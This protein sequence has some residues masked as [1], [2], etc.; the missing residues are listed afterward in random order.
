MEDIPTLEQFEQA[1]DNVKIAG[2]ALTNG[3]KDSFQS[4][5]AFPRHFDK[6]LV[7]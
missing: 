4:C 5:D 7:R 1:Q 3:V 2:A 6:R